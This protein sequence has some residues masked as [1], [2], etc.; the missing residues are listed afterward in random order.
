MS[1]R[2]RTRRTA[3]ARVAQVVAEPLGRRRPSPPSPPRCRAVR[4]RARWRRARPRGPATA[5][6][7]WSRVVEEGDVGVVLGVV[8]APSSMR[9]GLLRRPRP[10]SSPPNCTIRQPSPSGQ[11][12]QGLRVEVLDP[13]ASAGPA[14]AS[15][16]SRAIGPC[17]R[18]A[19]RRRRRRDVGVAEHHQGRVRGRHGHQLQLG[20]QHGDQRRLAADEQPGDVEAVL[21]QQGVQVVAG[22]AARDVREAGADLVGVGRRAAAATAGRSRPARSPCRSISAYSSSLV[23]PHQNRVPS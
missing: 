20:A 5:R 9:V 19:G 17:G 2:S 15:M 1:L 11:L 18:I 16:P 13:A 21:R 7:S 22:D 10:W 23:S 6:C 12:G 8:P 3:S 14:C 4:G